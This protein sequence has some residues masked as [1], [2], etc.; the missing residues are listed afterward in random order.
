M[1]LFKQMKDMKAMVGAAPGL[2]QQGQEM[3]ANAHAMQ[4]AQMAQA[5][6]MQQ[7][8]HPAASAI[9]AEHLVAISGVDLATYSW[10]SKQVANSGYNQA[11]APGFAAQ[12]GISSTDWDAAAAGWGARMTN[13]P[14]LGAEFRRHFDVS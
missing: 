11:L 13:V 10:V 6:Q 4:S 2:F 14:G 8:A 5:A 7:N 12:R 3:T 9:G 1:G